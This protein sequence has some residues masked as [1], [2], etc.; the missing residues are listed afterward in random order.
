M[1]SPS[2]RQGAAGTATKEEV[3]S[4]L[5]KALI[6]LM[7]I[8][9]CGGVAED[10]SQQ[11]TDN[12][13]TTTGALT[14][15]ECNSRVAVVC[16]GALPTACVASCIALASGPPGILLCGFGCGI[17]TLVC[18]DVVAQ[19]LNPSP[20]GTPSGGGT[21]STSSGTATGCQ[22][23]DATLPAATNGWTDTGI[24][25]TGATR[26]EVDVNGRVVYAPAGATQGPDES[27]HPGGGWTDCSPSA[28]NRC[29]A[30]CGTFPFRTVMGKFGSGYPFVV[31]SHFEGPSTTA[32]NLY[33]TLNDCDF[34]DNSG[35]FSVHVSI[36]R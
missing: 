7:L 33:L 30:G 17:T 22:E 19:C 28:S 15:S 9:G 23:Y 14:V 31:G 2:L 1:H 10:E 29:Q 34:G 21:G 11:N 13:D 3:M 18:A 5:Y 16:G 26:V 20:D 25:A 27:S 4:Y 12:I 6:V 8:G 36:C 32:G 24:L 35:A